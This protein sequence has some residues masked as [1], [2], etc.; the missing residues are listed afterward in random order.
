M[1]PAAGALTDACLQLAA[2]CGGPVAALPCCFTGTAAGAP[3]ALRRV[4]GVGLAA[5][6]DRA[7]RLEAAGYTTDFAAIPCCVTPVNRALVAVPRR[8]EA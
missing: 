4:L 3:Q 2:T 1:F 6:V 8:R 5:D 7:Y